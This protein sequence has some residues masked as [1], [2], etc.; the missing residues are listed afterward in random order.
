[1]NRFKHSPVDLGYSDLAVENGEN[2]RRYVTP[3]GAAY[4][5][6]T[7]ILGSIGKEH[8]KTWRENVGDAEADRICHHA[9]TRGTAMHEIVERY[10]DNNPDY[11][12]PSDMPHQRALFKSIRSILDSHIN[13]VILQECPLYSDTLRTAGRV[14]LVAN[15]NGTYSIVDFKTSR[16]R[17][18]AKDIS[19]Y[20][21]QATAY[22]IMF[23]ERTGIKIN[24]IV[25]IMAVDDDPQPIVFIEKTKNFIKP[26]YDTLT[27]YYLTNK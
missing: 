13:E 16:R 3:G 26:L 5:S 22:A 23:E 20:F 18:S 1:M 25:I 9:A 11:F 14:D 7:T 8:L 17:K 21:Q 27:Q 10:L 6:I 19:N 2:G 12:L 24:Q 4:A 15:Y